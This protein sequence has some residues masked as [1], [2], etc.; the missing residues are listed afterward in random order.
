M[1]RPPRSKQR[2][3][4]LAHVCSGAVVGHEGCGW[5]R[6]SH[7]CLGGCGHSDRMLLRTSSLQLLKPRRL[8]AWPEGTCSVHYAP[9][10]GQPRAGDGT[11]QR[12]GSQKGWE[13]S[14]ESPGALGTSGWRAGG[15]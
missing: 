4:T 11:K 1:E 2:V 8:G 12:E 6:N 9:V 10:P 14:G 5:G 13:A 3:P 7:S 15:S